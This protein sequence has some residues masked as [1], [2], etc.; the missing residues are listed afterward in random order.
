MGSSDQEVQLLVKVIYESRLKNV[1]ASMTVDQF[2]RFESSSY[3]VGDFAKIR[4]RD[5]GDEGC[6]F[7]ADAIAVFGGYNCYNDVED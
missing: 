1:S 2:V 5:Y 3:L 7:I 6:K 4:Q